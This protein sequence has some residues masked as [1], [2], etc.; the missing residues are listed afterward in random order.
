MGTLKFSTKSYLCN[1]KSKLIFGF[2]DWY[3]F[4]PT[5]IFDSLLHQII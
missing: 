2:H 3:L 5:F 1:K 4:L